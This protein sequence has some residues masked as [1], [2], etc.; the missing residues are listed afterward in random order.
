MD[1]SIFARLFSVLSDDDAE[2]IW[3]R[4]IKDFYSSGGD[5]FVS[6]PLNGWTLLHYASE[7][8]FIDVVEWLLAEG[9][10]INVKDSKGSTPY[11]VALD[12]SID[13]A[14]QYE[15]PEIDFTLVIRLIELGANIEA[16]SEDG[17]SRESI[18]EDYGSK[19]KDQYKA[20]VKS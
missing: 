12:S 2:S 10:D 14:I 19:A 7:N 8:L 18:L 20:A 3:L 1:D 13:S 6:Y 5:I 9:V 11:L 16:S 17:I 15:E 4:E